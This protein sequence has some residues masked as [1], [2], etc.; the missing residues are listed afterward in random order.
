M[1]PQQQRHY[2]HNGTGH[3]EPN[4]MFGILELRHMHPCTDPLAIPLRGSEWYRD[5][6][7]WRQGAV[8]RNT[9]ACEREHDR[10]AN[11]SLQVDESRAKDF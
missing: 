1:R 7:R 3:R 4:K 2:E 9:Y 8:M 6:S 10:A 11:S 5:T